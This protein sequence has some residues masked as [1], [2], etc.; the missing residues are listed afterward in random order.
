MARTQRWQVPQDVKLEVEIM[1]KNLPFGAEEFKRM[2]LGSYD[3]FLE[4]DKIDKTLYKKVREEY[5]VLLYSSRNSR[6]LY[7]LEI[8]A[9]SDA[10]KTYLLPPFFKLK[11]KQKA[12][13]LAHEAIVRI[14][15]QDY[16]LALTFDGQYLDYV[17]NQ[18]TAM[19][20]F[21]TL[22]IITKANGEQSLPILRYVEERL[23]RSVLTRDF[24]DDGLFYNGK[25]LKNH[26]IKGLLSLNENVPGYADI[27]ADAVIHD[28]KSGIEYITQSYSKEELKNHC[29]ESKEYSRI[30]HKE[31]IVFIDCASLSRGEVFGLIFNLRFPKK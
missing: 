18:D 13:I 8:F 6:L 19:K 10:K 25:S 24:S 30:E 31:K 12:Q 29:G 7:A 26:G 2:T 22:A 21:K 14:F 5:S 20:F 9:V 3:T 27:F 11:S 28:G 17:S 1:A 23:G 15:N 16:K 4:V